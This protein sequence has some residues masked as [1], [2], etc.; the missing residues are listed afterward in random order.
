MATKT[1]LKSWWAKIG[2]ALAIALPSVFGGYQLSGYANKSPYETTSYGV[3]FTH[4][5]GTKDTFFRKEAVVI[6]TAKVDSLK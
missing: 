4:P 3:V 2:F 6:D 5:S 1:G